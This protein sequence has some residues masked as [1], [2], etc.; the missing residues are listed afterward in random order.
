MSN[1]K[2]EKL[3]NIC[4]I[5]KWIQYNRIELSESWKFPV[6]NW[7]IEPSWY[8]ENFNKNSNTITIS[9]WGNSCWYINF[10][11]TK[12]WSWWHC[13]TLEW[14]KCNTYF[15]YQSLKHKE[16]DIMK[17]RVGSWL[18]NIQK[19]DIES[20]SISF[21]ENIKEQEKIADILGSV[22]ELIENTD[23][24]IEKYKSIKKG[25]MNDLFTKGINV[26]TW[27]PH[28]EFKDSE[29]GKIPKEWEVVR[30]GELLKVWII[31]DI[32]DWNHWE[33][34]PKSTDFVD[35][36]IP[37]IMATDISKSKIDF[38][39]CKKISYEQFKLLRIWFSEWW[40]VLLSHKAS[41]WFTAIVPDNKNIMLT[42]QVTYYRIWNKNKLNNK[43]LLYFFQSPWFQNYLNNLSA[44]STRS[45]IWI[46]EQK[47]LVIKYTKNIKEQEKIAEILSEVDNKIF[48]EQEYKEKLLS[49]KKGLMN[50]LLSGKVRVEI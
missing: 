15:L 5:I 27:K 42:P 12:F 28:T 34:H 10:V 8:S 14:V 47:N 31:L 25:L 4:N 33:I 30:L 41:I 26:E 49:L 38:D 36:W 2:T 13:Y 37:F 17:M 11:K 44:Q 1:W 18:P 43:Y 16:I 39:N 45:Y 21:P 50:D 19:K 7:G 35:Y 29:L 22:D 40:D 32:Q 20:F 9:E 23:K 46:T 6:I 3:A 24:V 48:K